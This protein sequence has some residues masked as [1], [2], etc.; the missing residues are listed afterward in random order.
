LDGNAEMPK[1]PPPHY[2]EPIVPADFKIDND[3][4]AQG[5]ALYGKCFNCHGD[6]MFAGG[7]APD[8]RASVI[9]TDFESFKSVLNDG[10][11]TYMGMPKFAEITD[12]Q[13]EALMHYIRKT[14]KETLPV[15]EN[16]VKNNDV[17]MSS[18]NSGH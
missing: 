7:M 17:E 12:D 4:A 18:V 1:L 15:Y 3:L 5:S 16:L 9:A 8:L 11:F 10:A 13:I 2:P 14:A 6:G